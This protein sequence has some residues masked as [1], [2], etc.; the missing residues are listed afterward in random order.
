MDNGRTKV[1]LEFDASDLPMLAEALGLARN[2]ALMNGQP[3]AQQRLETL[4][5]MVNAMVPAGARIFDG[6]VWSEICLALYD[7]GDWKVSIHRHSWRGKY[8]HEGY[9]LVSVG[10]KERKSRNS[11][12]PYE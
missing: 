7:G 1:M 2:T 3:V 8:R 11:H 9:I 5:R 4:R 6:E 10:H 12:S